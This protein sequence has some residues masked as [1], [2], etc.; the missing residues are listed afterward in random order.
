MSTEKMEQII[1][2]AGIMFVP[3]RFE[4]PLRCL[5]WGCMDHREPLGREIDLV[6]ELLRY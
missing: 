4:R 3:D 6:E 1:A 5:Q 2:D